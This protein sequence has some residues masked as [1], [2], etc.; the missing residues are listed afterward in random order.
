MFCCCCCFQIGAS[1]SIFHPKASRV[2]FRTHQIRA[3]PFGIFTR[4]LVRLF[5]ITK[6]NSRSAPYLHVPG[7]I[8]VADSWLVSVALELYVRGHLLERHFRSK[9][10]P[11]GLV[12]VHPCLFVY[13][14]ICGA[15]LQDLETYICVFLHLGRGSRFSF[16]ARGYSGL[17]SIYQKRRWR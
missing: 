9:L 11:S 10:D 17:R 8:F 4:L 6:Q 16:T 7:R 3:L 15:Y 14:D 2:P 12:H 1:Q 5:F 13:I